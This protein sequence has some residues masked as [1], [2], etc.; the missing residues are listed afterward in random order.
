MPQ[1][2]LHLHFLLVF[3]S[4]CTWKAVVP[5]T[6][7]AGDLRL[8]AVLLLVVGLVSL[9]LFLQDIFYMSVEMSDLEEAEAGAGELVRG[10]ALER[11]GHM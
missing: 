7:P 3:G 2:V 10:T 4:Y 11:S 9:V 1:L 5:P 6:L 8:W